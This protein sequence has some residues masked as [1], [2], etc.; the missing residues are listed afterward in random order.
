LFKWLFFN[1]PLRLFKNSQIVAT[2][3]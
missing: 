2:A 1:N 3:V